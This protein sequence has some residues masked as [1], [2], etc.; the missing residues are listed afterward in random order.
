MTEAVWN[1]E[2][3][4]VNDEEEEDDAAGKPHVPGKPGAVLRL[5][6]NG[7]AL[8][9]GLTI[10]ERYHNGIDDVDDDAGEEDEFYNPDQQVAG[11]ESGVFLESDATVRFVQ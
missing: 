9:T 4:K 7:I 3:T 10:G 2:G 11:H 1:E 8:W 6:I 5:V